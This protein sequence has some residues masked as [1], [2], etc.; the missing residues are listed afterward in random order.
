VNSYEFSLDC[1]SHAKWLHKLRY[2]EKPVYQ[3][4]IKELENIV[5]DIQIFSTVDLFLIYRRCKGNTVFLYSGNLL[6]I[7]VVTAERWSFPLHGSTN[8]FNVSS[9]TRLLWISAFKWKKQREQ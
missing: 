1:S 3:K 2:N 6:W 9:A 4:N 8:W 5:L 7:S